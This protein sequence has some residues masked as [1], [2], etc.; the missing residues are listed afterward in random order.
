MTCLDSER[1]KPAKGLIAGSKLELTV[2]NMEYWKQ[3]FSSL[4]LI[5]LTQTLP[6]AN[7]SRCLFG[8]IA[9]PE[10]QRLLD[11]RAGI[12]RIEDL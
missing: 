4:G 8:R 11:G 10:A 2:E 12:L 7:L 3:C 9:A 5:V 1:K 6:A